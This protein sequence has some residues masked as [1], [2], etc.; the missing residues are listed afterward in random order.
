[1][2]CRARQN[3][4]FRVFVARWHSVHQLLPWGGHGLERSLLRN[5]H[6]PATVILGRDKRLERGLAQGCNIKILGRLRAPLSCSRFGVWI[7]TTAP[8]RRGSRLQKACSL[9]RA[10]ILFLSS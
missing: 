10:T 7:N 1:M 6:S 5:D 3:F 4:H 2:K 9:C 8:R